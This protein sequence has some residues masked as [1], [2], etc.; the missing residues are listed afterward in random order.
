MM[1]ALLT[2]SQL[3]LVGVAGTLADDAYGLVSAS[4]IDA[5]APVVAIAGL[6]IFLVLGV[7]EWRELPR[8]RRRL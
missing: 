1:R 3:A 4:A 2:S 8:G 6:V 5:A 7:L